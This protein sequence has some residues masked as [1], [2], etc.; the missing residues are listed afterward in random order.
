[1][2]LLNWAVSDNTEPAF[3]ST[4]CSSK[5]AGNRSTSGWP[6]E[7]SIGAPV[8]P[9]CCR[10]RKPLNFARCKRGAHSSRRSSKKSLLAGRLE[11]DYR[12]MCGAWEMGIEI[13]ERKF[14]FNVTCRDHAH[15]IKRAPPPN[16]VG[17][18]CVHLYADLATHGISHLAAQ[19]FLA[20][21]K[22]D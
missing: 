14:S 3:A 16:D 6:A 19:T 4:V 5:A 21:S 13:L 8:R 1:M 18:A 17:V 10:S 2:L 20:G 7:L 15:S 9:V 11:L 12:I 22:H